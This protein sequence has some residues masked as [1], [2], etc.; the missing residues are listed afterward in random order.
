[1]FPQL[2]F[3]NSKQELVLRPMTCPHHCIVFKNQHYSSR[4]LPVTFCEDA[5]LFRYEASGAL[6][7]LERTRQMTLFDSHTFI[8][9][10]KDSIIKTIRREINIMQ[11][12]LTD[13]SIRLDYYRL[14]LNNSDE[15]DEG[16]YIKDSDV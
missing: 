10:D 9:H 7:G 11:Q 8:Q 13:F 12:V 14:S 16:K 6:I 15:S 5:T 2:S 4:D 3:A 1:M